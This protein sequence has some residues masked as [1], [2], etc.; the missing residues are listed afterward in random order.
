MINERLPA[1]QSA[2]LCIVPI[3]LFP[4]K[5]R[6]Y[7]NQFQDRIK[8]G[9]AT[10]GRPARVFSE[11][12]CIPI[13]SGRTRARELIEDT[14]LHASDRMAGDSGTILRGVRLLGPG[15][16]TR[17]HGLSEVRT[18]TGSSRTRGRTVCFRPVG[19]ASG[20]AAPQEGVENQVV[21]GAV[22]GRSE[23]VVFAAPVEGESGS[24]P[25][26]IRRARAGRWA[27]SASQVAGGW[28]RTSERLN[29]PG[30]LFPRKQ[31]RGRS[32]RVER[33]VHSDCL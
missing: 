9:G 2:H 30:E 5:L 13:T 18:A 28:T 10:K 27:T 31:N 1:S 16:R 25:S 24:G 15:L 33:I 23:G 19:I 3:P 29:F 32:T 8:K 12:S 11:C 4:H 21:S 17:A 20:P 14:Y 22:E 6:S 7:R 26:V